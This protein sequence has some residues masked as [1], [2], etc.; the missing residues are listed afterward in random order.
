[1]SKIY[2]YKELK[3]RFPTKEAVAD[4]REWVTTCLKKHNLEKLIVIYGSSIWGT[5]SRFEDQHTRR[6]D[7][8]VAIS[9]EADRSGKNE[10][11]SYT[12]AM[13][14][15][16]FFFFCDSVSQSTRVP[17]EVIKAGTAGYYQAL[18]N[19]STADHFR[20]LARRFPKS[21]YRAFKRPMK[22]NF[23]ARLD[24]LFEYISKM[25]ETFN[26]AFNPSVIMS[27]SHNSQYTAEFWRSTRHPVHD[28]F[29][30]LGKFENFPDHLIRKVLGREKSLP[31]PDSKQ[32]IRRV[33]R[34]FSYAW[35]FKDQLLPL[36][37]ETWTASEE[38]ESLL[39][40]VEAGL[41][42]RLYYDGLANIAKRIIKATFNI[43]ENMS[44][45]DYWGCVKHWN[46]PSLLAITRIPKDTPVII[47]HHHREGTGWVSVE[48][49][50][51]D[52]G[53]PKKGVNYTHDFATKAI[54]G[55]DPDGP[56]IIGWERIPQVMLHRH[57]NLQW[58]K[59]PID[60]E[61]GWF[62]YK[63]E[64]GELHSIRPCAAELVETFKRETD[65][66]IVGDKEIDNIKRYYKRFAKAA[67]DPTLSPVTKYNKKRKKKESVAV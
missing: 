33:F 46:I 28:M 5:H 59:D 38:Y 4:A 14:E 50:I 19:P 40:D 22:V 24:D 23:K 29:D 58:I 56:N 7:V 52:F 30:L 8:D 10:D 27:D 26:S 35:A 48:T 62:W 53:N 20:L 21:S 34:E 32:N 18:I 65:E 61:N 41:S 17:I 47:L 15:K 37:E 57:N 11:S 31:C 66:E 60:P 44:E 36:F 55:T 25:H 54:Y 12:P 9:S 51:E 67:L 45:K 1:M 6:S 2:T 42:E 49:L 3:W 13:N 64:S 63:T 39:D 16:G 43:F